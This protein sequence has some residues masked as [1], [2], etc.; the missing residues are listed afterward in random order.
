[1]L[2]TTKMAAASSFTNLQR[3]YSALPSVLILGF[4]EHTH[5]FLTI[6][7]HLLPK[8]SDE[9]VFW[10]PK[11]WK[12]Y[13]PKAQNTRAFPR[14]RSSASATFSGSVYFRVCVVT[15]PVKAPSSHSKVK[16]M[17]SKK[18]FCGRHASWSNFRQC[19]VGAWGAVPLTPGTPLPAVG[20]GAPVRS[21][22]KT[23]GSLHLPY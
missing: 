13:L 22:E 8:I 2:S 12:I 20:S 21:I 1:M 23:T 16:R 15:F 19:I 4:G 14:M 18:I 10:M 3:S 6:N 17:L 5:S 7:A 9:C 11:T